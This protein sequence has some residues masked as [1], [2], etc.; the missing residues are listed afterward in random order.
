V[1]SKND[2]AWKTYISKNNLSLDG[3]PYRVIAKQ[4][5]EQTGREPRLMAK[6][7]E[8]A[9]VSKPLSEQ[10]YTLLAVTNLEYVL[11]QGTTFTEVPA[12]TDARKVSA[13]LPFSLVTAGRGTGE[14]E[15]LDN[16]FNS[17]ILQDFSGCDPLFLT[18]RGKE[19]SRNFDFYINN[20]QLSLQTDGVQIEVDG[21]YEGERDVIL[22][23]AKIGNR[24]HFNIR[25]LYYPYRH[26]SLIAPQKRIRPILFLY[27]LL[28]ASYTF[29]EYKFSSQNI[30]D[31]IE[32]VRCCR[33]NLTPGKGLRLSDLIDVGFETTSDLIPQADDFNK[34]L[35]LLT[36]INS[37]L[38]TAQDIADYFGFEPRQSYYYAE[39]AK[40]L[41][42]ICD[43][44]FQLTERGTQFLRTPPKDQQLLAAKLL[45]NS[46]L[47][48]RLISVAR[49]KG[50]YA[51][52]D[53][54]QAILDVG[55]YN[56]TTS[57]RRK[58]TVMSW[59][60]W[61]ANQIGC[62]REQEGKY[63]IN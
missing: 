26:F 34:V 11:F 25:Q 22:V 45:I 46:E 19:R 48:R 18:I 3:Q 39:A 5:R 33:Y 55:K 50:Y 23:E 6:F 62:F 17:G 27:D 42:L 4:L 38:D 14:S 54:V 40:F 28:S 51:K 52:D 32:L 35:E 56:L 16:A 1:V 8:P 2:Y 58:Q 31:S 7:D 53:V 30:F 59:S 60:N 15:Y 57:N 24:K 61:L 43:E 44:G 29:Y 63:F 49:R 47:F 37:G 10:N 20:A 36:V 9:Q 13:S 41:G 21:G 12:C